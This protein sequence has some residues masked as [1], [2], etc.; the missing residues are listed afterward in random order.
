MANLARA[1]MLN[2]LLAALYLVLG[3]ITFGASVQYG[4]VT[5]GWSLPCCWS[6]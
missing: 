6:G 3:R 5:S 2:G 1:V 4:N